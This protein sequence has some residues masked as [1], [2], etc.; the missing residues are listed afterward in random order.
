MEP[1]FKIELLFTAEQVAPF[2]EAIAFVC[3]GFPKVVFA[4]VAGLRKSLA[5]QNPDL[6]PGFDAWMADLY[7]YV[8]SAA[9][10]GDVIAVKIGQSDPVRI[11]EERLQ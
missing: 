2:G 11:S 7:R 6:V 5:E 8:Q 9:V 3:I 10:A 4:K 1:E